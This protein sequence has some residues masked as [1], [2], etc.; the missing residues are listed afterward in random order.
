MNQKLTIPKL[1]E[2]IKDYNSKNKSNKILYS[3]L[4]K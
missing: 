3:K 1:K 2:I 4:N